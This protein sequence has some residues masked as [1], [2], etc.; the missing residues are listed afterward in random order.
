MTT[1]VIRNGKLVEK[2]YEYT[3]SGPSVIS[4]SM[5]PAKHM[6]TGR[7]IDSKS[8]FRAETKA[9]GCIEIGTEPIRPRK[10]VRLDRGQRREAIRKAI[11]DLRN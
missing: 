1:Y 4:D 3:P 7:I 11:Y 10:P 8:R 2:T 9:S 5:A 6:A